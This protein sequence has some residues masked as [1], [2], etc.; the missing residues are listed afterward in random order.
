[1]TWMGDGDRP[2]NIDGG[3]ARVMPRFDNKTLRNPYA[4]KEYDKISRS[5]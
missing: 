5:W 2:V 3:A 4:Y 1:M